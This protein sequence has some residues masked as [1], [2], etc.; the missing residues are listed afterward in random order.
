MK[1]FGDVGFCGEKKVWKVDETKLRKYQ[2]L[3]KDVEKGREKR[4]DDEF[5]DV[6]AAWNT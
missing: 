2:T 5:I 1:V 3:K 4:P 6:N